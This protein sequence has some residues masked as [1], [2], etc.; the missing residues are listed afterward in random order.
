MKRNW[1]LLCISVLVVFSACLFVFWFLRNRNEDGRKPADLQ[2][3]RM[4]RFG[5]LASVCLSVRDEEG[6]PIEDALVRM[7]FS[8]PELDDPAGKIS[9]RTNAEGRFKATKKTNFSCSW[10]VSKEGYHSSKG[11]V[12]FPTQYSQ[13]P[14]SEKRWTETPTEETVVLERKSSAEFIRGMRYLSKSR[15]AMNTWMGFDCL[16]GDCV[17]PFGHGTISHFLFR[18]EHET[19][20]ETPH[21][22]FWEASTRLSVLVP[23]GGLE[24]HEESPGSSSPFV[25]M[26]PEVFPTN[27]IEFLIHRDN[28]MILEDT[29][30]PKT[31]Y[32]LFRT[33][34]DSDDPN[35]FHVGLLKILYFSKTNVQFE[36]FFNTK[37]GD[38]H[39]DA[40]YDTPRTVDR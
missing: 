26:A 7:Y 35:S 34:P 4:Q 10:I 33:G 25:F 15:I 30:L 39:T 32:I 12:H 17:P 6:L 20:S 40:D 36:Y 19:I 14:A 3:M 31:G 2:I 37:D 9:G 29:R 28:E 8:Q 18:L 38:L 16:K 23:E 21:D 24:T 13:A 11:N 1:R 27:Q 22:R 5:A